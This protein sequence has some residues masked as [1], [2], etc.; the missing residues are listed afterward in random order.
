MK[1]N[2]IIYTYIIFTE[3]RNYPQKKLE[4]GGDE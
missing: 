4:K 2:S 1:T 3:E